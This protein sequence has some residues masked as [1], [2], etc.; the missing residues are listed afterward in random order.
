MLQE[1]R[2]Y[3]VIMVM[4]L[5]HKALDLRAIS[6]TVRTDI[7]NF[8]SFG[9]EKIDPQ[10]LMFHVEQVAPR[11][12][13]AHMPLSTSVVAFNAVNFD[14][15][16]RV[17]ND[18]DLATVL[19][20]EPLKPQEIIVDPSEVNMWLDKLLDAQAPKQKEIRQKKIVANLST[21]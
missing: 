18:I 8:L 3:E 13:I 17:I 19:P 7:H 6:S 20:F 1:R 12:R 11:I 9:S 16:M 21:Y 2:G 4:A 10:E 14:P 15:G 5:Q